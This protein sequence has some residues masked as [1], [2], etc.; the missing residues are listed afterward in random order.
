MG[1][2]R[3]L[4]IIT[5]LWRGGAPNT[6]L[7]LVRGLEG[8][9]FR[10]TL[11]TGLAEEPAWDLLGTPA[12]SGVRVL[13]LPTLTREL[14]PVSDLRA[15]LALVRLLRREKPDLLHVHTSKAGFLGRLAARLTGIR[16]VIYSPHGSILAGYFSPRTTRLFARLDALAARF[17]DRIVCCTP[18]EIGEYLAAG[19]GR[20]EQYV[21]I[22]NG[23]DA[24]AYALRAAP[25]EQTRAALGLPAGSRPV[26]CAGRLVP[27]KGQ[28]YLLQA[29]PSVL[30]GEPRAL[31]L[32]AGEGPD[33]A[34][35]RAQAYATGVAGSV[36][37]LGFRED[38]SSLLACAEILVLPS[39]NEGFGMALVEAMAMGKPAVASAVGGVPEVVLDGGT[40]LL[41]PPGD[42][43]ALATAIRHLLEDPAA[44]QQMGEAGRERARKAFSRETFLGGHRDLYGE[45]LGRSRH[46]GV[47][48]A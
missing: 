22:P 11:V 39:L 24:E 36:R 33:E 12:T 27:V 47:I 42:P 48:H 16:P 6:T 44:A 21:V 5:R 37:F 18:K 9:G 35:L 32:L 2:P 1:P 25:P 3:V 13:P 15:L 7:D 38:L 17:T 4:H 10:Q 23:L 46:P 20:P 30:T 34:V 40:G 29:W 43:G 8:D 14:R 26:L 45:L 28:T 19:I 41:V 31:L